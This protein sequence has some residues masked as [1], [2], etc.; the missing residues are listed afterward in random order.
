MKYM[1]FCKEERGGRKRRREKGRRKRKEEIETDSNEQ[2]GE[3]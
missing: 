3:I 2:V 1:K